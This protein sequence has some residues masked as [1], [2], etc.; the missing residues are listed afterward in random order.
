VFEY[1]NTAYEMLILGQ[2]MS[3]HQIE[4]DYQKTQGKGNQGPARNDIP[5]Q[6]S[7]DLAPRMQVNPQPQYSMNPTEVSEKSLIPALFQIA[8]RADDIESVRALR[9]ALASSRT[10][11]A[12][13]MLDAKRVEGIL[14]ALGK[15]KKAL[16]RVT[17]GRLEKKFSLNDGAI[18]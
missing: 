12:E 6:F 2:R 3:A 10:P 1:S 15:R 16:R 8:A 9:H 5:A 7:A 14:K 11:L 13:M 17:S 18:A 4:G